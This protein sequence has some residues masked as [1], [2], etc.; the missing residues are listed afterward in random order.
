VQV[1]TLDTSGY[2]AATDTSEYA[3]TQISGA[4]SLTVNDPEPQQIV[5]VG[6]DRPFAL[7]VLPPTEPITGELVAGKINDTLD[8]LLSDDNSFTVGEAKMFPFGSDNRGDENQMGILCYRQTID[9]NP[10]S[11]NFGDRRWEF[12]LFPRAFVISREGGLTGDAE[13]RTYT[14]RPQYVTKHIWGTTLSTSTEGANQAQGFRGVSVYKPR[15][16]SFLGDN[17]ATDFAF[18]TAYPA[19]STDKIAVW[20]AGVLTTANITKATTGVQWTTAPTTD[21]MIVIFYEHNV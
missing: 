10:S 21:A 5:H 9:T 18:D 6:D 2:P 20:V 1:F 12:R 19:F 16:V 3:G 17:T 15:I 14:V 11:G 13:E 7:D 8:A 4:R